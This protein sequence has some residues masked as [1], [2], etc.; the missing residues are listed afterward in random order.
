MIQRI[1]EKMKLPRED[2]G[3]GGMWDVGSCA[4]PMPREVESNDEAHA[5]RSV[6]FLA[7]FSQLGLVVVAEEDIVGG[8]GDEVDEDFDE[9]VVERCAVWGAEEGRVD[10]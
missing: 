2:V 10:V 4:H 9:R 1:W 7:D 6:T 8:C 3:H 5:K